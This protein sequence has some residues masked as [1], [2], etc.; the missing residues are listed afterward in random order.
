[1]IPGR[2][3]TTTLVLNMILDPVST[4]IPR[5]EA[6]MIRGRVSNTISGPVSSMNNSQVH[7]M[8]PHPQLLGP[9]VHNQVPTKTSHLCIDHNNNGNNNGSPLPTKT[10]HLRIDHNNNGNNNGSPLPTV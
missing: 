10:T 5:P 3:F 6:S 8:M 1:M 2:V 9:M 4:M 7:F